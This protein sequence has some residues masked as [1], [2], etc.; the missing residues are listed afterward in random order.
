MAYLD[1]AQGYLL[2]DHPAQPGAEVFSLYRDS[3]LTPDEYLNTYFDT[4][5][6]G[7][8]PGLGVTGAV[9]VDRFQGGP[10]RCMA[11]CERNG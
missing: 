7:T 1:F 11:I 5:D 9:P 3:D 10:E 8:A 2:S 4:G 6:E